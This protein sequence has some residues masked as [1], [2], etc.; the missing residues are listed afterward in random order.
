[1]GRYSATQNTT[2]HHN[3][4]TGFQALQSN[5]TGNYNT[6]I[7]YSADV[8]SSDLT[9]STAI[10]YNAKV[11][12]SNKIVLGNADA[13][14]VGGYGA[15]SNYS[16]KRLKENIVYRNE[17]GLN[18]ILRLKPA[19]FNY[20]DDTNKRRRDG[21]I[22]QDVRQALN[23][24]GIQFSG[25]IIDDD[26]VKTMNLSYSEFVIP[27]INAV[28]ELKAENDLLKTENGHHELRIETLESRLSVIESLLKISSEK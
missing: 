21:L 1:L 20:I 26:P 3:T 9:N 8:T 25:L 16:D 24:L 2:G 7:G 13:K 12:A 4:A 28:R 27:L 15:W 23:E 18:L 10:G 22:A 19:S 14:T 11:N 5:T 6:A 17:P